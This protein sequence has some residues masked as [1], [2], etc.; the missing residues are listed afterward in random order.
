MAR[1]KE[2]VGQINIFDIYCD[3]ENFNPTLADVPTQ[4]ETIIEQQNDDTSLK[5]DRLLDEDDKPIGT[6]S[7]G[8]ALYGSDDPSLMYSVDKKEIDFRTEV[9]PLFYKLCAE[10]LVMQTMGDTR[11][12]FY[13]PKKTRLLVE[14]RSL[15]SKPYNADTVDR[16][17]AVRNDIVVFDIEDHVKSRKIAYEP[18]EKFIRRVSIRKTDDDFSDLRDQPVNIAKDR[19][20]F[21]PKKYFEGERYFNLTEARVLDDFDKFCD[22]IKRSDSTA[23]RSR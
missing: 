13:I 2:A 1:V 21:I 9:R 22:F 19:K 10:V 18:L 8:L 23:Q 11:D 17:F 20:F 12:I 4:R 5:V 6:T 7:T 15:K 3:L 14:P 16:L